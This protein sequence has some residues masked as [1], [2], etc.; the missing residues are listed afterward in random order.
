MA[1]KTVFLET[2]D[3]VK[4]CSCGNCAKICPVNALTM[5]ENIEGFFY[6]EIDKTK[7]VGCGLCA[8]VCV[9]NAKTDFGNALCSYAVQHKDPEILKKS[10]SGGVFFAVAKW[11]IDRGGIVFGCVFDDDMR[12][13]MAQAKTLE[14]CVPMHG[15]KYV[16]ADL[17]GSFE[18]VKELLEEGRSVL[19]TGSP[20]MIASLKLFL[21]QTDISGLYTLEFLCHGVPSRKL[22]GANVKYLEQ[23]YRGK[24]IAYSFRDKTLGWGQA[25]N[26]RFDNGKQKYL[27][28]SWQPY[29]CGYIKGYLNRYSCYDCPFEGESRCADITMGDFWGAYS[30][31]HERRRASNGVSLMIV[32][33]QKGMKIFDDVKDGLTLVESS[34]EE[35]AK[36]NGTLRRR[37]T[38][39]VIAKER[40]K[41][42]EDFI[43][44]GFGYVARQ[45]YLRSEPTLRRMLKRYLPLKV[46]KLIKKIKG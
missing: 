44:H 4:C 18:K 39:A 2:G 24:V 32:S 27:D 5:T 26:V 9:Y 10:S 17:N 20:C 41:I 42:Y 13:I 7:C 33:S 30:L 8:S 3:K 12:P 29:H 40:E 36:E 28:A 25:T 21:G 14:E 46:Q 19:Y 37:K 1:E 35:M 6:P 23:K 43:A 38:G 45:K 34:V 22:F 16:E 11:M 31:F 15:S